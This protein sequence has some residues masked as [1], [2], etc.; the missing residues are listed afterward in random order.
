MALAVVAA[1]AQATFPGRNGNIL[2]DVTVDS[3]G[4]IVAVDPDTGASTVLTSGARS[5]AASPDGTKIAFSR[6]GAVWVMNADG[7]DEVQ[8]NQGWTTDGM[9]SWSPDGTRIVFRNNLDDNGPK[10]YVMDA[11]GQ[12]PHRI[13]SSDVI[14]TDDDPEWSPDGEW[15]AF[16]RRE[17]GLMKVRPDGTDRTLLVVS[18]REPSWS[19]DGQKILH[20]KP[21]TGLYTI[22]ANGTNPAT[23]TTN[24]GGEGAFSP[25]GSKIA[26][27]SGSGCCF[28]WTMNADGSNRSQLAPIQGNEFDWTP[29]PV[30]NYPRPKAASPLRVSLVVGFP[31]CTSPNGWHGPPL[32]HPSCGDGFNPPTGNSQHVTVGTPDTNGAAAN[33]VGSLRMA[34][35]P[36]IPS[37]PADEADVALQ[38]SATDIRCKAAGAPATCGMPN[39]VGADYVG[40]LQARVALRIT[41]RDNAPSPG[42]GAGTTVDIPYVFTV[43]CT[44]TTGN[45]GSTC[46]V[47]TTADAVLPGAVKEKL[48]AIWQLGQV[49]VL[50]GGPDGDVD[51]AANSQVFLRQGIFI[52]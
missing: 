6:F 23:V 43:P 45:I 42:V 44:E 50:D 40:E 19:P 20:T 32:E 38:V 29:I 27:G 2:L 16:E 28:L 46:E 24:A 34:V 7:S 10:L 30:D 3:S 26:F 48:R 15:I 33:S 18:G 25:D 4:D 51:T 49:E 1:P 17:E 39:V 8:L 9:P 5:P 14:R 52:P 36:G 11:D 41:D 47:G 35:Q 31:Q 37:T 22:D 21:T 13:T 12:N